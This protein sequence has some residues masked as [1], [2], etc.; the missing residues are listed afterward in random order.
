M[1]RRYH[2]EQAPRTR[3]MGRIVMKW[4]GGLITDKSSL[5]TILPSRISSLA[6]TARMIHE[7]GHDLIIV[8]GAG[9]FGHIRAKEYR[10]AEGN[11]SDL[12]QVEAIQLV[13]QDMDS[14]H[15][16]V[17]DALEP[18]TV[19]SHPPRDF[20][21]NTGSDF[22]G[23]L[24]P[25]HSPGIH[26]TFGDV[27]DCEP[28]K[29]F[30]ILS[31]DD[32]MLRLSNELPDVVCTIFAMGGTPG[33]MSD[34]SP[35]ATLIPLLTEDIGFSGIHDTEI[36]VTGGIFL[37][38]DRAFQIAKQVN[39]VWFIDGHHPERMIEILNDGDAIGTRIISR[40]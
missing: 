23:D 36:D 37:K 10:L 33:V 2:F 7:M 20:V 35:D 4:G 19:Q 6:R 34:S 15:Q 12:D 31:G 13:R 14:L 21:T 39:H 32:L 27:V 38:V 11:I 8:H 17:L 25:F 5:C 29:D 40:E 3:A 22:S 16:H 18:L 24:G 26:V 30:G 9:S 28:P 1:K